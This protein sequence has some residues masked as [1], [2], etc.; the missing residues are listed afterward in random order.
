MHN[1][2]QVSVTIRKLVQKNTNYFSFLVLSLEKKSLVAMKWRENFVCVMFR[3][4][5]VC[6]S[7]RKFASFNRRK[8]L[9]KVSHYQC[10]S[11]YTPSTLGSYYYRNNLFF[12]YKQMFHLLIN[13]VLSQ[14]HPLWKTQHLIFLRKGSWD[15]EFSS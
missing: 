3:R 8:L 11:R 7:S 12:Q 6:S 10:N 1:F 9:S 4:L 15:L 13:S 2:Q 5:K 14:M